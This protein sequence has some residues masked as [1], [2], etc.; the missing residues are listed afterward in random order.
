MHGNRQNEETAQ[1]NKDRVNQTT[2]KKTETKSVHTKSHVETGIR[3]KWAT[4][5]NGQDKGK[6][7]AEVSNNE[8]IMCKKV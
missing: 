1:R 5:R 6:L 2:S 4:C 3:V 8:Q 7:H